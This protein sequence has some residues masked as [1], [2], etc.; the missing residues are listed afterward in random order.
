MLDAQRGQ[1]IAGTPDPT[2]R[3]ARRA[4]RRIAALLLAL[5]VALAAADPPMSDKEAAV[6]AAFLYRLS[7]FVNWSDAAF[8]GP[9]SPL[10]FCLVSDPPSPIAPLL[11]VHT[12]QR[13]VGQRRIEVEQLAPGNAVEHC[14]LVYLEG[15]AALPGPAQ[16]GK[17]VVVDS[18]QGLARG[19]ILAL[20]AEPDANQQ[21]RLSFVS[22]REALTQSGVSLNAR[23]LQLVR[24]EDEGG[25][26]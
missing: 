11:H 18:L 23:L 24:F 7:F 10:R 5:P 1:P 21:K 17:L 12:Q 25:G 3:T 6:R 19:G 22:R 8:A 26:S 4:R 9:D 14:N 15:D 16:N 13:S 20:L 2:R